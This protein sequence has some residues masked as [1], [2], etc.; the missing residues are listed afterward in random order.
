MKTT[1]DIPDGV[2]ADVMHF[3]GAKTVE[4]AVVMAIEDFNRHQKVAT[5][6]AEA[7]TFLQMPTNDEIEAPDIARAQRLDRSAAESFCGPQETRSEIQLFPISPEA[8]VVTS[9]MIKEPLGDS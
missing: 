3:T 8:K 4:E 9:E 1:I 7:G 6:L 2:L 5:I